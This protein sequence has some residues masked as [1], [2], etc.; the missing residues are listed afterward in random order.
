MCELY[1]PLRGYRQW[2]QWIYCKTSLIDH[3]HR[4]TTPIID[5]FICV[6]D[7]HSYKPLQQ[8]SKSLNQPT[9]EMDHLKS[10][11]RLVLLCV[12]KYIYIFADR[13]LKPVAPKVDQKSYNKLRQWNIF[14][15][16]KSVVWHRRGSNPQPHTREATERSDRQHHDPISHS[17]TLSLYWPN[18]Y[19]LY[20]INGVCSYK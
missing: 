8:Y 18:Q 20:A 5:C 15:F 3:L 19:S 2:H 14:H 17:V 9:R 7:D 1:N 16:C 11:T 13:V 10:N 4:S 12:H 6:P